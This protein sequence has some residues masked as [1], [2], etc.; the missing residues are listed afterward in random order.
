MLFLETFKGLGFITGLICFSG[1]PVCTYM[2]LGL[3]KVFYVAAI[4]IN[5]NSVNFHMRFSRPTE[6]DKELA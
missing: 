1:K 3:G 2:V 4:V 5:C 6:E